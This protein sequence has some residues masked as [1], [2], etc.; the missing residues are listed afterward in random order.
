MFYYDLHCY[1]KKQKKKHK[2]MVI[3][4]RGFLFFRDAN[5]KVRQEAP[6]T[7][8]HNTNHKLH[9]LPKPFC[10]LNFFLL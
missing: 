8:S 5:K 10:S 7:S 6:F 3:M 4:E 9:S 1:F 2:K